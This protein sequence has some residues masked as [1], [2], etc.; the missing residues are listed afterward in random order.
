MF[1]NL[2]IG[3]RLGLGFGIVVLMLMIIS[4]IAYSRLAMLNSEMDGL[5]KD[6][7]PKTVLANDIIDAI[8]A[9][10]R[11][12]RNSLLV[13][14]EQ[15]MV[16][17]LDRIPAERKKIG[18]ALEKLTASIKSDA[19]K[20]VLKRMVDSRAAYVPLQE[21][22]DTLMRAG[23]RD[24]GSEL[25][26]GEMRKVFNEYIKNVN[27]LIDFQ[28]KLME[29]AGGEADEMAVAAER[30]VLLIAAAAV[31]VAVGFA[32]WVTVSITKPLNVAVGVADELA[33]GNLT[34]KIESDSKDETGRLLTSMGNMVGKL[35]HI[36]GEVN[37]ASEALNN[38]AGQVSQ[39]AQ[40]L[41]QSSS[42]QAASVEELSLIHI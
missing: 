26:M 29:K 11:I 42:E 4:G 15:N 39:T 40:S 3:V 22:F 36:I 27:E 21:K 28:T 19:G 10:G 2:K 31:V 14:G 1:K 25:L 30:M 5:M 20:A 8:N 23:K 18:D 35:S 7:F 17:E 6:K 41:S 24:D 32:W 16:K 9:I 34:V 12:Q 38:A 33:G 37:T 13:K